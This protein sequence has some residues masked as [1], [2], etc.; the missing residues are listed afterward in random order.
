M[1]A[2]TKTV[3]FH[4]PVPDLRTFRRLDADKLDPNVREKLEIEEGRADYVDGGLPRSFE[5]T[6]EIM[7]FTTGA[8]VVS[9][10]GEILAEFEGADAASRAERAMSTARVTY[11]MDF[12]T[13][14]AV[15]PKRASRAIVVTTDG[16]A[17]E[18][19][20]F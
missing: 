9:E 15:K 11:Q 4:V 3:E 17:E 2:E 6:E 14:D 12:E 18:N 7:E 13:E 1:T 10:E 16:V 19:I 8:A 5:I 20:P